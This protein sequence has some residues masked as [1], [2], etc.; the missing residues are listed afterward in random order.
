[1]PHFARSDRLGVCLPILLC[2]VSFARP[3]AQAPQVAGGPPQQAAAIANGVILGQVVDA[4]SGRPVIGAMV[5]LGSP[6][7]TAT[8]ADDLI[9]L[10][11]GVLPGRSASGPLPIVTDGNGQFMFN[12]LERGTY[13]L[14]VTVTGYAPGAYGRRRVDGPT[15]TIELAPDERVADA[16]VRLWK[17]GSISGTV[18]DDTGEP[19]VSATVRAMRRQLVNGRPRY[20]SSATAYTD[21]R[22]Q[23]RFGSL[24]PGDYLVSLPL[25]T[26]A[27]PLTNVEEYLA[28]SAKVTS[29]M[30]MSEM[31]LNN[32][33]RA[34]SAGSSGVRFGDMQ[35]SAPGYRGLDVPIVEGGR[36]MVFPTT[37]F[38]A[39]PT[40][41]EASAISI[42]SG[43]ART[44]ADLH[45]KL[46]PSLRITGT[47][48]GSDGPAGNVG[49]RLVPASDLTSRDFDSEVATTVTDAA[50]RFTLL[51]VTP[52]QYLVRAHRIQ[53]GPMQMIEQSMTVV[54]GAVV[55]G[56]FSSGSGGP[57]YG[58][59]MYAEQQVSVG[60]TDV[61]GVALTFRPGAEVSGQVVFEGAATP[62]TPQRLTLLSVSLL[63][64]DGRG[65]DTPPLLRVGEDGRFRTN[66]FPPGRYRLNIASPGAPWTVS[67]ISAGGVDL[68][69]RGLELG[70]A[71]VGDVVVTFS[72]RVGELSGTLQGDAAR[73]NGAQVTAIPVDYQ[74]WIA[75]GSNPVLQAT[76]FAGKT[77]TYQLR[78]PLAGDY[79]V[80]ALE[81]PVT[82]ESDPAL[83][84]SIARAGT[85][86]TM[87]AGD[88]RTLAL[89]LAVLR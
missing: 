86:V 70:T 5:T 46:V 24:L 51:G 78:L 21:D 3:R 47:L 69:R 10:N 58:A 8:T 79:F 39:A 75:G 41:A 36:L 84:A 33:S 9:M 88:K 73:I 53:R 82:I 49:V 29:P 66:G 44:N 13:A 85:R 7:P 67:A 20:Q 12:R 81:T 28:K 42:K 26:T 40:A 52:G 77:G 87:A 14:T 61:T 43:E 54:G 19:V 34:P 89:S 76:T 23:Y 15:Q 50:G 57:Q 1:M 71:H 74:S 59:T 4:E 63:P 2:A 22:G 17:Y 83:L 45:V 80:I 65:G 6:R 38:P 35:V 68:L 62:P 16:Q 11:A 55:G 31:F 30:D 27:V 32:D 56:A 48:A 37:F 64:L 72:D 60:E 18:H 25:N